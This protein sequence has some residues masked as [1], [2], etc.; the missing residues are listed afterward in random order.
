M[1]ADKYSEIV[2]LVSRIEVEGKSVTAINDWRAEEVDAMLLET[3][4]K[5]KYLVEAR[6][7]DTALITR[8]A[9]KGPLLDYGGPRLPLVIVRFQGNPD[10][11]LR[12]DKPVDILGLSRKGPQFDPDSLYTTMPLTEIK[13]I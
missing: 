13:F 2:E 12:L 6:P 8:L 5:A 4:S 10:R 1:A 11:S 7:A 3:K 9:E